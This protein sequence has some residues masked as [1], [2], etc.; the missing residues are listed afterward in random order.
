[1]VAALYGTVALLPDTL[2]PIV[3]GFIINKL[4]GDPG[5]LR[6]GPAELE[7]RCGVPT[8]GVLPYLRDVALDA[9]D[10]L[11][12]DGRRPRPASSAAQGDELDIAAIR[13]P[14]IANFTDLDALAIEPGLSVRLV[15][16]VGALGHPDLII[17]PGT[18]ATVS[19]LE[20]LR[21]T[22]LAEAVAP[23]PILGICGGYQMLGQ[24]IVDL[25]ESGRG[26]V[27][28]LGLLDV[29]TTFEPTKVTRQRTGRALLPASGAG[30]ARSHRLTGYQIHHGRTT[31]HDP[32]IT[33][34]DAYGTEPEGATTGRPIWGTSLHG[35][36][37]EDGFRTAFLTQLATLSDKTWTPAGVSFAAARQHQLDRLADM[38]E[39]HLDLSA[40]EAL[41]S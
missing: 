31:T 2:R 15:D 29:D 20:W 12:L 9:E 36:F 23:H 40:L 10:S 8:I 4:R 41:L 6:D 39:S 18:K 5:M 27:L 19:D 38:L 34:D 28:G 35:L 1:V 30:R 3:K 13:L 21:G 26:E 24:R 22:G 33:L 37:E 7:R 32:W 11:A 16:R 14:R 25:V 17:I